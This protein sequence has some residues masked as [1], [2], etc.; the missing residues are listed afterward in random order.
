MVNNVIAQAT[1]GERKIVDGV[2]TVADV[3]AKLNLSSNYIGSINGTPSDDS[4]DVAAGDFVTFA[5]KVKGQAKPTTK[6]VMPKG[7]VK[8]TKVTK[9]TTKK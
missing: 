4:D 7:K 6:K 3:K 9:K 8:P 2:A 1:G 5:E